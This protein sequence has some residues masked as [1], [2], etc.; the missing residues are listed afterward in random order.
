L[1]NL[2]AWFGGDG[3][4]R[5]LAALVVGG[6]AGVDGRTVFFRLLM[7]YLSAA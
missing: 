2:Y 4:D 6:A 3:F 7:L 5:G 1:V